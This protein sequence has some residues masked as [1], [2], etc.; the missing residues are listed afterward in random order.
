LPRRVTPVPAAPALTEAQADALRELTNV[1]AGHG[2]R[3]LST[4]LGGEKFGLWPPLARRLGASQLT[5]LLGG[6]GAP[7]TSLSVELRGDV[8]GAMA[9]VFSDPH[10][11][12]LTKR[13]VGAAEDGRLQ[14]PEVALRDAAN[15]CSVLTKSPLLLR[16]L[17]LMLQIA[18][19]TSFGACLSIPTLDERVWRETEPHTPNPHARLE[20]VA[21]LN[22]AGI[23]TGILIAPL[24]P[25]INDEAELVDR[26]VSISEE[27]GA[28][29][30]NAIALHLRPG[31]KEVFMSWLSAARPDLVPR[32]DELYEGRAYAPP[33]ERSRIGSLVRAPNLST[34]PR[35]SRQARLEARR[36]RRATE[37][38]EPRVVQTSLF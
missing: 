22:R 32:Y 20:A 37:R 14:T 21:E 12:A 29:F 3:A 4:L 9:L 11:Q 10:V 27:A 31:V 35:Y 34:D 38:A 5:A 18:E 36:R 8:G 2:A 15:P 24:M 6:A 26:I 25:G 30:V 28:T 1:A 23:P 17:S 33:A 16:D 7:L 13:L 19:R